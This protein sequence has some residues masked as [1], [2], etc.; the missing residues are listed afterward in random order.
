MVNSISM[1]DFMC[2]EDCEVIDVR[3]ADE[4]ASGHVPGCMNIP[5]MTLESKI[6]TL[7]SSKTYFMMCHSGSRSEYACMIAKSKGYKAINILGG[8]M[9]YKGEIS[10]EV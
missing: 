7:D 4:F 2:L 3:E 10:Y 1:K 8:M 5:V 9:S 6:A